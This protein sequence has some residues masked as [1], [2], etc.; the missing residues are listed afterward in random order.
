MSAQADRYWRERT[1]V[2]YL[3]AL[4]AGDLDAIASLW[5]QAATDPDLEELLHEL[6]EGLEVEEGLETELATD[7]ARVVE[8]ARLHM[9]SAFPPDIPP[10]PLTASDVARRLEA[11]PGFG[12][13][14]TTD[15]AA[16]AR[17]LAEATPVPVDM[18]QAL[19]D[20]WLNGLGI[21][22]GTTYRRAF[23]KVAILMDMGRCQQESRLA[24]A[25]Q[26][27]PNR[28]EKGGQP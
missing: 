16:H 12:R 28:D 18:R 24:A 27:K 7:A 22:A 25:R 3:D 4:D 15:R 23:R 5:E 1:A 11:E 17:L 20:R 9:P 26:T 6:N 21:L 14:D 19:L 13:F 8:L 2:R 10:G